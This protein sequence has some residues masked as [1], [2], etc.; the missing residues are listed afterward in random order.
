MGQC[1]AGRPGG[2]RT[3]ARCPGRERGRACRSG[4]DAGARR[5]RGQGGLALGGD[6]PGGGERWRGKSGSVGGHGAHRQGGGTDHHLGPGRHGV[7]GHAQPGQ[8]GDVGEPGDGTDRPAE[9]PDGDVEESPN[10]GRVELAACA[11]GQLL[12]GGDRAHGLLV[13]TARGH[14]LEGV[15][16][17]DD[18]APERE[19]LPRQPKR[20]PRAVIVLV[21]L[22]DRQAPWTKPGSQRGDEAPALQRMSADLFPFRVVELALLVQGGGV[23][24]QLA[25]V[26]EQGRPAQ[27]V[28]VGQGEMELVGDHVRE[29]PDPFGV[30]TRLAVMTAERRRQGKDLLGHR[31]G[32]RGAGVVAAHLG[33]RPPLEV[34][35]QA[36]PPGHLQALGRSVGEE[37]RHLQQGGQGEEAPTNPLRTGEDE[38][39]RRQHRHPPKR[40]VAHASPVRD[41]ASHRDCGRNRQGEGNGHGGDREHRA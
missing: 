20:V 21:V 4:R 12:P 18:A 31:G 35:G 26:M 9:P 38:H 24:G 37:H 16:H 34:P 13:G 15:R 11:P 32:H 23:D 14:D 25:D 41:K 30:A 40:Q 22:L 19:L 8:D 7:P 39:R 28:P 36:R 29:G 3:G 17:R 1:G 10:Y 2:R 27:A 33:P 6:R 5:R